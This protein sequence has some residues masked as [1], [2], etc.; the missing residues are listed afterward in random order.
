[1]TTL[2]TQSISARILL[3]GTTKPSIPCVDFAASTGLDEHDA[4]FVPCLDLKKLSIPESFDKSANFYLCFFPVL[5]L[6]N[7]IT[8]IDDKSKSFLQIERLAVNF[9]SAFAIQFENLSSSN[10]SS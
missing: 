1:M 2:N 9:E 5:C 4:A 3:A 8:P 6:V 10:H 7:E